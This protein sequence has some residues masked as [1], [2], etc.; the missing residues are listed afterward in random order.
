MLKIYTDGS[1]LSKKDHPNSRKGG[2]GIVMYSD[3][4][5]IKKISKGYSNTTVSRM[6]LKAIETALKAL[7]KDQKAIIYSDSQYCVFSFLKKW[8]WKWE[9]QGWVDISKVGGKRLNHDLL[10]SLLDEYRKFPEGNIEFVHVKGHKG[11]EGNEL[12]D[13]LADYKQFSEYEQDLSEEKRVKPKDNHYLCD[14]T[15]VDIY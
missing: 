15:E 3:N 14:A 9:K 1:A 2:I 4:Q 13:S 10:K 12:A 8:L 7:S 5:I 11:L 6:E